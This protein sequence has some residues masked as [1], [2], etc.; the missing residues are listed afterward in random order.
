[1][2]MLRTGFFF[3]LFVGAFLLTGAAEASWAH[4]HLKKAWQ[5]QLSVQE[6][7]DLTE[8][9]ETVDLATQDGYWTVVLLAVHHDAI[10][11][12]E[13]A[14]AE[15]GRLDDSKKFKRDMRLDTIRAA[16]SLDAGDLTTAAKQA[17]RAVMAAAGTEPIDFVGILF[18]AHALRAAA[19]VQIAAATPDDA[20]KRRQATRALAAWEG[21]A[22][23]R[24]VPAALVEALASRAEFAEE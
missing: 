6:V 3:C 4:T 2:G 10:G 14:C 15:V 11:D 12:Q 16:C 1:M 8:A 9:V 19:L 21:A 24:N 23:E 5:G 17:G 7:E 13:R 18:R 22:R 20:G